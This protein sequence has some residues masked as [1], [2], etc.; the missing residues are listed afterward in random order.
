MKARWLMQAIMVALVSSSLLVVSVWAQTRG[1]A[2]PA[3]PQTHS[4]K[5]DPQINAQ[6]QK[7]SVKE[8][9]KRFETNDREV[10]AKRSEIAEV[11]NLRPGMAV[12]D[13]GAGTG[14]FT[15]LFANAV[16]SYG[17]V[18]AVDVSK[19]F[20]DHI[21]AGAKMRGQPQI[22]TIRGTQESTNLPA[23]S[24]DVAFLCDVYH[25][26][27]NHESILASI[28]QALRPRGLL[29]LVEFDRVEGKS[30]TFVLNHVRAG[31]AE[32]R[33]EIE[34]AGF[35]PLPVSQG[36]RLKENFIAKYQKIEKLGVKAKID[37]VRSGRHD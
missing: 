8:F 18:Y 29:V 20:L 21:A 5:V 24:V 10:F 25:H 33:R 36:P 35:E 9:I 1:T 14:L 19:D 16:G 12:A 11:L 28:Y 6:F 3:Q 7:G 15:R 34:G 31:Q 13:V 23:G 2:D 17:K 22:E 32:F 30:T 27:E 4:K 37:R 26:L